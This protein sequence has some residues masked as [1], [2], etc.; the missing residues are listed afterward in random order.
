VRAAL[1]LVALG[2][3]VG[4]AGCGDGGGSECVPRCGDR[5]CGLDPACGVSCGECPSGAVCNAE[6]RCGQPAPE[7]L[8]VCAGYV[9]DS[10]C[11]F[12]ED[13]CGFAGD[14]QCDCGGACGW[15][16]ADC[17]AKACRADGRCEEGCAADPDCGTPPCPCDY[18]REVCEAGA[19]CSADACGCD[20]DCAEGGA[21]CGPDG[22][23]DPACTRETDPDC[24]GEPLDG[25][26]CCV[27]DCGERLCGD[28][29]CGGSCGPCAAGEQCFEGR[30]VVNHCGN[31]GFLGCCDGDTPVW[32]EGGELV[33][34]DCA[35]QTCGW[36]DADQGYWCGGAGEAPGGDPPV[37]CD[38]GACTADCTGR[39]CGSDGCGGTCGDCPEGQACGADG[40]CA[41]GGCGSVT[42]LGCCDGDTP[43]WCEDGELVEGDCAGAPCGWVDAQ[44]GYY[45]D[46][47]GEAPG[48]EPP[49]ACDFGACTPECGE[50]VCGDDGCGGSCGDCNDGETCTAAGAC[51]PAACTPDCGGKACGDDGCGGSCGAC[52]VLQRCDAGA[53]EDVLD[54]G[55][56][57][58]LGCCD[59]DVPVWCEAGELVY[60]DCAAEGLAQTCGWVD[61][62]T[63]YYC[64]GEG[65]APAGDPPLACDYGTP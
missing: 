31:V 16:K 13:V 2:V 9:D 22:H 59:G 34:G 44:T 46:G 10:S 42:Y 8:T 38:Y 25:Q 26:L 33:E 53:C 39:A 20:P 51:E 5:S 3:L 21:A 32:C 35:R 27:P 43:V 60:A 6:G 49:L 11:C 52:E 28:D 57:G 18:T 19:P 29:G 58:A 23:C 56:I 37:D 45:C 4:L 36:T 54:C 24:A 7:S 30:C 40:Q 62:E 55:T 64:E 15:D 14:G 47:S 50:R 41:A 61:G 12:T 48:G 63:G 1:I 17:T 65:A